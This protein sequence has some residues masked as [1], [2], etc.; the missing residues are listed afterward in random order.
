MIKLG[1][2]DNFDEK[3]EEE[4]VVR[5]L[6]MLLISLNED[7]LGQCQGDQFE[8]LRVRDSSRTS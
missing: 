5:K 6:E 7:E 2:G 8:R 3:T 1:F 4:R